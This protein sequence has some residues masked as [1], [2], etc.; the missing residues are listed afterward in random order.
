MEIGCNLPDSFKITL[1]V[2]IDDRGYFCINAK[3]NNEY[4]MDF[5]IDTKAISLA[6]EEDIKKINSNYLGMSPLSTRNM[7]GQ[8]EKFPLYYFD[9]FEIPPLKFN[10]PSF[11]SISSTNH[12]HDMMYKNILGVNLLKHLQWK[13]SID[14]RQM[15]LF[16]NNNA[17]LLNEETEGFLK[18]ENGLRDNNI[19]LSYPFETEHN[20]FT[21]DLGFLGEISINNESFRK[22]N[23]HFPY[24]KI[25]TD[26]A[27]SIDTTYVFEGLEIKINDINV[28]N[29]QLIYSTKINRNLI[30]AKIMHRFNFILAYSYYKKE[31]SSEHLFIQSVKNFNSLTFEPYVNKFGFQI[32]KIEDGLIISH[33]EI[34]GMAEIAGLKI[35]DKVLSVDNKRFDTKTESNKEEDFFTYLANKNKTEILIERNNEIIKFQLILNQSKTNMEGAH[36][37]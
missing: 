8:K 12:L 11:F 37:G 7:Y 21:L 27:A 15:I 19:I 4:D 26:R 9:S 32:R 2:N 30:G 31:T 18:I 16:D 24:K 20:H 25:L 6:K 33:I 22:I 1:P 29:C 34:G 28:P 36:I 5:I 3:I 13:F 17:S 23:Q 35:R 14:D 10:N